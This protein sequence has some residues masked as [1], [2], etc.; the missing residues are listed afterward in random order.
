VRSMPA[1]ADRT[2]PRPSACSCSQPLRRMAVRRA[3][4]IKRLR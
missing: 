4:T 3:P 2:C 1:E